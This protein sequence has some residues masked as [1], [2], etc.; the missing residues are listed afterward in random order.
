MKSGGIA[1][2]TTKD[3]PQTIDTAPF[4]LTKSKNGR[5]LRSTVDEEWTQKAFDGTTLNKGRAAEETLEEIKTTQLTPTGKIEEGQNETD[6]AVNVT[7]FLR[8]PGEL[9]VTRST[10]D[11]FAHNLLRKATG[12]EIYPA[13]VDLEGF[14]EQTPNAEPWMGW[15]SDA[16]G[17]LDAGS[18][19]GD[20]S[21]EPDI[22]RYIKEYQ[23]TQLGLQ[24]VEYNGRLLKLVLSRSGWIAVY[25]PK[26]LGDI[27]FARFLRE[28]VQQH[29]QPAL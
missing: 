5:T 8:I 23:N 17:P 22:E 4:P 16:D 18:A 24:N 2:I 27:E 12:E 6:I 26:E 20:I 13:V 3:S 21:S 14:V 29:V 28:R 1:V 19:Y 7:D 25:E 15:F 9:I 11:E 10:H